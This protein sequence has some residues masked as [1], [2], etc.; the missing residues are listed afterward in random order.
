MFSTRS[1]DTFQ[2]SSNE[3][4]AQEKVFTVGSTCVHF[5][6]TSDRYTSRFLHQNYP[7]VSQTKS[8]SVAQSYLSVV[9]Q[10]ALKS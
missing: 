3:L 10:A 8:T 1:Y 5:K 6:T 7:K 4:K 2:S 9:A